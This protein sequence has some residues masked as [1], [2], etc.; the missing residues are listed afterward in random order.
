M[1]GAS[2]VQPYSTRQTHAVMNLI[3]TLVMEVLTESSL[4]T[5]STLPQLVSSMAMYIEARQNEKRSH[6]EHVEE[7]EAVVPKGFPI[8]N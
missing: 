3:Q 5:P 6:A 1:I 7:R 2:N 8:Q 4:S